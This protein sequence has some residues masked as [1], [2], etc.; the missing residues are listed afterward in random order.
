MIAKA[1][2][3]DSRLRCLSLGFVSLTALAAATLPAFAD[4]DCVDVLSPSAIA[5]FAPCQDSEQ[6]LDLNAAI[7]EQNMP[8]QTAPS[9]DSVPWIATNPQDLPA[10]F[11]SSDTGL[12]VRT[13][14]G[15][16]RDYNAR[17]ASPTIQQSDFG[18]PVTTNFD[19]PKAPVAPKSPIDVWTNLDV[20]G[21]EGS[22]D[23]STRAGVGADYKFNKAATVGVSI[24]RG[25]ARSVSSTGT[26]EDQKAAAYLSLQATPLLSLD[27]RTEWQA[28]NSEFASSTGAAEHGALIL[29]PKVNHSFKLDTDTTLSPYVTYQRQLDVSASRK[30]GT[31]AAADITQSAGAGVTY[32]KSDAYSLSL[33]AD[34]DN[35][36]ATEE[37]Q[38]VSSKFQLNVPLR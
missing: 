16:V 19:M 8:A 31:A 13:S 18:T 9:S 14:L 3:F 38:S 15:T 33:S 11:N 21:Y 12:S 20:N 34:V 36:G 17:S 37:A 2:K 28:G 35:F 7:L 27:A 32:S 29:A 22:R 30:D 10:N 26:E 24:E 25:D 4:D 23:Q 5:D 1:R 6:Q